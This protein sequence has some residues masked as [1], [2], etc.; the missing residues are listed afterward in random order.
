MEFF[1]TPGSMGRAVLP[2]FSSAATT[3]GLAKVWRSAYRIVP[4]AKPPPHFLFN[5]TPTNIHQPPVADARWTNRLA[6]ATSKA[7]VKMQLRLFRHR[8]AFHYLFHQVNAPARTIQFIAQQLV[9]RANGKTEPA[10]DTAPQY[11]VCFLSF[12]SILN[13]I[14]ETGLHFIIPDTSCRGSV[15]RRDR[16][17]PSGGGV[18]FIIPGASG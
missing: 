7:P 3:P 11:G 17:F 2:S 13:E 15:C 9:C 5:N 4:A 1:S 14:G 16:I 6:G 8:R 10:M 12:G 18:I